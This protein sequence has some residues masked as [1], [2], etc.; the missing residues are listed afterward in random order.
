MNQFLHSKDRMHL[1][2]SYLSHLHDQVPMGPREIF[3]LGLQIDQHTHIEPSYS[4]SPYA[5][6]SFKFSQR[7]R[8]S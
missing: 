2:S 3:V 1:A 4:F 7:K 6:L 5:S 8:K